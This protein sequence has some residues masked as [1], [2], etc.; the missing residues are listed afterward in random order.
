M[1]GKPNIHARFRPLTR[2]QHPKRHYMRGIVC[3]LRLLH[4]LLSDP[5]FHS[6]AD[7]YQNRH[8]MLINSNIKNLCVGNK[9]AGNDMPLLMRLLCHARILFIPVIGMHPLGPKHRMQIK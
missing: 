3:P 7:A 1:P 9:N 8:N 5:Y 6:V 4:D 2:E